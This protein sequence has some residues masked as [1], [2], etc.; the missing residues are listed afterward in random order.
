MILFAIMAVDRH[1]RQ[2]HRPAR[3][4]PYIIKLDVSAT[5]IGNVFLSTRRIA[6]TVCCLAVHTA[7]IRMMFA[8]AR[9][10]RLP[11]GPHVAR[12]SAAARCRSSRRSSSASWRSCCLLINIGNQSAFLVIT[13]IGDHHVLHRLPA[14]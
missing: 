5:P 10:N 11:A 14:A 7:T 3:G 8:M 4:L 1:P 13:S 9:D 6:I 12:V 2:E